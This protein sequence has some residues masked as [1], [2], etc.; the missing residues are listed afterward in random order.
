[1]SNLP[2]ILIPSEDR[3]EDTRFAKLKFS[4]L[5][6]KPPFTMLIVAPIGQ[7]KSSLTYSMLDK[8]YG[9][10]FDEL[11]VYNGTKDSNDAWLNLP[12][13]E[14]I[15]LNEWDEVEFFNYIKALEN[16]QLKRIREGKPPVN[17]GILFDDMVTDHI[18][19]R[20][21]ST[22]LDQFIIKIRHIPASLIMTTQSYK[23][24]SSTS[25]RNMTHL[26]ILAVNQD[27]IE[28]IAEEHSGLMTR[29]EFVKMY[30]SIITKQPRNY[31]VIDYRSPV[32]ER[33]KERFEKVLP[34]LKNDAE[35]S[36]R[37]KQN[38]SRSAVSLNKG[39][40]GKQGR[41]RP[42]GNSSSPDSGSEDE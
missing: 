19:S 7:G 24:I 37:S 1:M 41:S 21:R 13:K 2:H 23:L 27:E 39:S 25:R 32:P 18:F 11:I 10:Y 31:L 42:N 35:N 8:W 28:K 30:K 3:P 17:V 4:K 33:F 34:F 40:R 22:A 20:G 14:V 5:I 15:L 9:A 26:A 38:G 12:A 6:P 36:S 29:D 16:S